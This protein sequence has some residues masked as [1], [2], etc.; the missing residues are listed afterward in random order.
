M[1]IYRGWCLYS[2]LTQAEM[3]VRAPVLI[4]QFTHLVCIPI[5]LAS[6]SKNYPGLS[7]LLLGQDRKNATRE[8]HK[9]QPSKQYTREDIH[10]D[11]KVMVSP[12]PSGVE[13]LA[14][15]SRSRLSLLLANRQSSKLLAS[16]G[17]CF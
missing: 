13:L 7:Y 15:L 16:A 14:L 3:T 4:Q 12:L 9:R 11:R 1:S 6:L 2:S 8:K 10:L 5:A 17:L